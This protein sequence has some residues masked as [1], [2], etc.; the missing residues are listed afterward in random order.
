MEEISA[1]TLVQ[2]LYSVFPFVWLVILVLIKHIN[3]NWATLRFSKVICTNL[4]MSPPSLKFKRRVLEPQYMQ[5]K[6]KPKLQRQGT[7]PNTGYIRK[8][9]HV[10]SCWVSFW[11]WHWKIMPSRVTS[12]WNQNH[13]H[14]AGTS[15]LGLNSVQ[16]AVKDVWKVTVLCEATQSQCQLDMVWKLTEHNLLYHLQNKLSC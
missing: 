6:I 2:C 4:Q 12:F 7:C 11:M 13:Q 9:I 8:P 1:F 3:P 16:R 14:L 15:V 10:M 5:C